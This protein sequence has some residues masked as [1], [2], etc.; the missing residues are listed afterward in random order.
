MNEK[1]IIL[2]GVAAAVGVGLYLYS[3]MRGHPS[4][5]PQAITPSPTTPAPSGSSVAGKTTYSTMKDAAKAVSESSTHYEPAQLT[6]NEPS[7]IFWAPA[8]WVLE[9]NQKTPVTVWEAQKLAG[10]LAPSDATSWAEYHIRTVTGGTV[11]RIVFFTPRG[12]E[13]ARPA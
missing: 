8:A 3:R 12:M 4:S 9:K 2:I 5:T 6:S 10:L 1:A 7:T 11:T 13:Y